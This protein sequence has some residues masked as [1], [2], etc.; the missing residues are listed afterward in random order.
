[1]PSFDETYP[2]VTHWIKEQGWIELGYDGWRRS[3]IRALDEGGLIWEGGDPAQTLDETF[4]ELDTA[5]AQ[6]IREQFGR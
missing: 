2:H 6:W 3:W 5:L 4:R 1:M